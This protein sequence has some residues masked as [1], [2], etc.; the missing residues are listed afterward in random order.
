MMNDVTCRETI[1]T[2]ITSIT[3]YKIVAKE[4]SINFGECNKKTILHKSAVA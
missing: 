4:K 2:Y 1:P 3:K